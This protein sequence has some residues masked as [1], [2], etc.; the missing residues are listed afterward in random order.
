M[1]IVII[2]NTRLNKNAIYYYCRSM[3]TAFKKLN[4]TNVV[5]LVVRL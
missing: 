3:S 4:Q 1:S 5:A 2:I